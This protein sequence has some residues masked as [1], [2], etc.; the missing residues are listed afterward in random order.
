V[1]S[2]NLVDGKPVYYWVNKH[3]SSVPFDA[4][5]VAL[6]NST[7][8]VVQNLTLT[9]NGQGLLLVYTE[10]AT[11]INNNITHNTE[12]ILLSWSSKN[13]VIANN[14][15]E[16]NQTGISLYLSWNNNITANNI[17]RNDYGVSLFTSSKNML[18]SNSIANNTYNFKVIARAWMGLSD[19]VNDVDA[20]NTVDGKPICYWINMRDL[21]VPLDVGYV[22]LINCTNITVKN[23]N[24]TKNNE[25]ILLAYT[26]NSIITRNNI[27]NN[28]DG[29]QLYFSS[30]NGIFENNIT[31][32]EHD[33][34]GL[35]SS[36]NNNITAN[37]I[38]NNDCGI[39]LDESS[40]NSILA[41]NITNNDGGIWLFKSSSNR[42]YHNS[43]LNNMNQ[44][45]FFQSGYANIWDDGYPSGGNYWS[46]YMEVDLHSGPF[47]NVI[48]SDGIGDTALTIDEYN[49]DRYPLMAPIS[50]F[51][52]GTWNGASCNVDVVSNS[53]VSKFQ[54]NITEKTIR[55]NVTG[56]TGLGFCRVTIPNIIIQDMWHGN[57]TVLINDELWPFTNWTDTENTYIY[58]TY[59]HSEHE[60]TII[61]EFPS[62]TILPSL[63]ILT[64][65]AV[66]F[67]KKKFPACPKRSKEVAE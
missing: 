44:A 11:I 37:N 26:T 63:M 58:F 47:Q 6:V 52:A 9:R 28:G 42:L 62:A 13:T 57:Y 19:F 39:Y 7:N 2:S 23:L 35:D 21:S 67:A 51:N 38:V 30:K 4:G 45:R 48:G 15:A 50:V 40:N 59:Q 61:P 54:L 29:V 3:D 14:L 5:Y 16:N 60:I 65:L 53:T 43:F 1:D 64:M 18:R 34:I 12:G 41:N 33:G 20:S 17:T 56:E 8:I 24:L 31:Y 32:H 55:F 27:A 22:G 36:S 46:D 66:V 25:G 10:N 49:R